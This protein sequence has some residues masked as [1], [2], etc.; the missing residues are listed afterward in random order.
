[1]YPTRSRETSELLRVPP[2]IAE[3]APLQVALLPWELPTTD[4]RTVN[5]KPRYPAKRMFLDDGFSKAIT[6]DGRGAA[7]SRRGFYEAV[8]ILQFPYDVYEYIRGKEGPNDCPHCIWFP[9]SDSWYLGSGYETELLRKILAE[10]RSHD[11]GYQA[12]VC[13][14]FG[15]IGSLSTLQNLTA[16]AERCMERPE[17][18][19]IMYGTHP[20]VPRNRWGVRDIFPVGASLR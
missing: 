5:W 8:H 20:T 11:V 19:F 12:E 14:I 10:A 6:A 13:V 18:R 9:D 7:I 17:I 4:F 15:H 1:M 2:T 16:L 3:D